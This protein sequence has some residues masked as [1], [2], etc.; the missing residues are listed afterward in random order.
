VLV[1]PFKNSDCII[2]IKINQTI[3]R[4]TAITKCFIHLTVIEYPP[5]NNEQLSANPL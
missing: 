2:T 3:E 1:I 4:I 5:I